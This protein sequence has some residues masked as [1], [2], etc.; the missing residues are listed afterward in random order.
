MYYGDTVFIVRR[1]KIGCALLGHRGERIRDR[2]EVLEGKRQI[3]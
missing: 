3:N 1:D 2:G